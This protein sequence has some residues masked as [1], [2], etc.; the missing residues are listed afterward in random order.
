[1]SGAEALSIADHRENSD[2]SWDV[3]IVNL[4]GKSPSLEALEEDDGEPL[5]ASDDVRQRI[6]AHLPGVDWTGPT[7]GIFE[8]DGFSIEFKLGTDDPIANMMLHVRGTGDAIAAIIAF[9]RPLGWSVFDCSLSEFLDLEDPT[10]A[11]WEGFQ[12]FRDRVGG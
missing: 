9:A 2:M 3:M 6:S 4:G 10:G 7:R 8:G 5:G 1:M 12:A 11:G